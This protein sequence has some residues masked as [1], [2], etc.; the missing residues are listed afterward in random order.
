MFDTLPSGVR[1]EDCEPDDL[2]PPVDPDRHYEG[3]IEQ[4]MGGH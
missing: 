3:C 2:E 4:E 1:P